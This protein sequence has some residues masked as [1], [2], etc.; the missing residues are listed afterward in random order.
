M[1]FH[2]RRSKETA[3]FPI[4]NPLF[5]TWRLTKK[6][7]KL[8]GPA[9]RNSM[10]WSIE[11]RLSRI[12]QWFQNS[13]EQNDS[14]FIGGFVCALLNTTKQDRE[15]TNKTQPTHRDRRR[16]NTSLKLLN[17]YILSYWHCTNYRESGHY[18]RV[19]ASSSSASSSHA[20]PTSHY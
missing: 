5:H 15:K 8:I 2:F 11:H 7:T 16:N 13:N 6:F 4:A 18:W 3:T 1:L 20:T 9:G 14:T 10:P 19:P 12:V 17:M